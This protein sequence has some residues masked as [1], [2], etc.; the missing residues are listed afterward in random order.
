MK[1][2]ASV[3]LH[4][5]LLLGFVL[6]IVAIASAD[7]PRNSDVT[8]QI[9][10]DIIHDITCRK[11]E[12]E[13]SGDAERPFVTLA[14]AQSLD[15]KIALYLDDSCAQ[16]SSNFPISG[17]ESLLMTHAMRSIHDAI[18]VGGKTLSI[19]NPRLSNRFWGHVDDSIHQPR[20]VIVDTHLRHLESLGDSRRSQNLI[21][22]CSKEAAERHSGDDESDVTLL[23]LSLDDQGRIDLHS[24]LIKLRK[25]F[26]IQSVLVEGGSAILSTFGASSIADCLCVTVAPRL[27]GQRGVPSISSPVA[28]NHYL[29]R[30]RWF[31]L[32]SDCVLLSDWT[33]S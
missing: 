9:I 18:L 30:P 7:T 29:N 31:Q 17:K 26:G 19:D 2:P 1:T 28:L 15:G 14:F 11:Q 21:V 12:Y 8:L 23:S 13:E 6:L 25:E 4:R 27:L 5:W 22:C 16:T 3:V 32:G 20:P 33:K 24:V 10:Q